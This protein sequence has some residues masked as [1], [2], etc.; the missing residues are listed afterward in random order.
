MN[1]I[2]LM[3]ER[4]S[5]WSPD[6]WV[7]A[8]GGKH[9][10]NGQVTIEQEAEWLSVT[11]Y[12][13]VLD[14]FDDTERARLL[15]LVNEPLAYLVEWKGCTLLSHLLRSIPSGVRA[16]VDNDHGL[17]VPVFQVAGEPLDSWVRAASLS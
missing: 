5:A 12:D 7:Q 3:I 13:Q 15:E 2:V 14:D 11:R 16:A 4:E 9:L 1:S 17:L 10:G 8:A 6:G